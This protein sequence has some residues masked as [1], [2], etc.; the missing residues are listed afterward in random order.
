M[1]KREIAYTKQCVLATKDWDVYQVIIRKCI[2]SGAGRERLE[3]A[4]K[5][6]RTV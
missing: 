1:D 5:I 4:D 6:Q 2:K 3:K